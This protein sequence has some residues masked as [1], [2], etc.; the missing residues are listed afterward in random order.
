MPIMAVITDGVDVLDVLACGE[1]FTFA[2]KLLGAGVVLSL[3]IG[4]ELCTGPDNVYFPFI[5]ITICMQRLIQ[6]HS[7]CHG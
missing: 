6:I 4:C 2:V 3:A 7:M 1:D 5:S